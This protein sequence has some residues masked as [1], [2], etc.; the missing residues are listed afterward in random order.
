MTTK[1][2]YPT[3]TYTF[4]KF[5]VNNNLQKIYQNLGKPKPFDVTLR[6][7]LQ[8]LS[9]DE[10]ENYK[11]SNKL[12]LYYNISFNYKPKNIEIG[13]IVSEKVLPVFKDTLELFERVNKN[14]KQNI[15][16]VIPNQDKLRS[17]INN[18]NIKNFSFI[19]SVSNSF[20]I[21]NTK[22]SLEESDSD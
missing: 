8:A 6:D 13:S 10:Q 11:T 4:R 19:T 22:M 20:Q 17:V 14:K 2:M 18:N 5:L 9:K 12:D 15:F 1:I 21:K 16:I 3:C 7:G